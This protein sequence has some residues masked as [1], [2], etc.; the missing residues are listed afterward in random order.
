M[1]LTKMYLYWAGCTEIMFIP[2]LAKMRFPT[3]VSGGAKQLVE[4]IICK[5]AIGP[6]VWLSEHPDMQPLFARWQKG[7]MGIRSHFRI[8]CIAL[9]TPNKQWFVRL[10]LIMKE[11]EIARCILYSSK[12][13]SKLLKFQDDGSL[14]LIASID[15]INHPRCW[16]LRYARLGAAARTW[17]QPWS[18]DAGGRVID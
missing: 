3:S 2:I 16:S 13:V 11:Q 12:H 4:A 10:L 9:L 7:R 15:S 5:R 8:W 17:L 6:W 14:C 1:S 18:A